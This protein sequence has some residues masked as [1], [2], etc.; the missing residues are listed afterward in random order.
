MGIGSCPVNQ[1]RGIGIL[2]FVPS[3]VTID[4]WLPW[5][6]GEGE[7]NVQLFRFMNKFRHHD[8]IDYTC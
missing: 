1:S 8:Y 4:L 3:R 6:Q 5:F 2:S 7:D